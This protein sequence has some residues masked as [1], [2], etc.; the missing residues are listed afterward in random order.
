MSLAI[1]VWHH[2]TSLVMPKSDHLDRFFQPTLTLMIDS[3]IPGRTHLLFWGFGR[4][5]NFAIIWMRK[6]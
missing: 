1:T 5:T 3:N 4:P 6:K 2:E